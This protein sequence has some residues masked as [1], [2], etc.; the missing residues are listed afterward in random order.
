MTSPS[1]IL[2]PDALG[3]SIPAEP[4]ARL[5][6]FVEWRPLVWSRAVRQVVGDPSRF[7][8][9]RLL[10]LGFRSGRMSC[11][12]ASLGARVDAVDLPDCDPEGATRLSRELGVADRVNF[13][14]FDGDLGSLA[15]SCWDFVFTKSVLVVL[16]LVAAVTAIRRS[17][18]SGGQYLACEN[19][20]LPFGLNRLRRYRVGVTAETFAVL[21]RHF[22][23]VVVKKH[24][25]VVASI[26]AT[27]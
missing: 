5:D 24:L 16:P 4:I 9:K 22:T 7:R 8:G 10:E 21:R 15:A 1:L 12:F 11:Y 6:W 2:R 23:S 18:V 25:G 20:V 26:V 14:T 3:V 17:L 13:A 19:M 27:A